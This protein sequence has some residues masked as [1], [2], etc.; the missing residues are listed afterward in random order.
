[1]RL[2]ST[3]PSTSTPPSRRL[4]SAARS[5]WWGAR[6]CA[7]STAFTTWSACASAPCRAARRRSPTHRSGPRTATPW[8]RGWPRA[9]SPG[10][11]SPGSPLR[12]VGLLFARTVA[13]QGAAEQ[14]PAHQGHGDHEHAKG[15]CDRLGVRLGEHGPETAEAD[16]AR[17]EYGQA[18]DE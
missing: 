8:A 6:R 3:W 18:G 5:R 15:L 14:Q 10:A 9:W 11:P 13:G 1:G 4:T 16:R 12:N 7:S 2:S 17:D